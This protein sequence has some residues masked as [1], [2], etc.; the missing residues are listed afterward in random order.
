[1]LV[2][3]ICVHPGGNNDFRNAFTTLI[4][5]G[6]ECKMPLKAIDA[7]KQVEWN[8]K[9]SVKQMQTES[10]LAGYLDN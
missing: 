8:Y 5:S 2:P 3:S 1:M 9:T 4:R 6:T 7:R 10:L